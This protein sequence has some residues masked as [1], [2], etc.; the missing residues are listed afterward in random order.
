MAT[1]KYDVAI[2]VG[3]Y[4]ANGQKKN[5][6]QNIGVIMEGEHGPYLMLNALFTSHQLNML[7]NKDRRESLLCS[8]FAPKAD[9]D[10]KTPAPATAESLGDEVPF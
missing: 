10:K 2:K 8:L 3:E 6:Y 9:G 1:K 5:R 4:E 7:C